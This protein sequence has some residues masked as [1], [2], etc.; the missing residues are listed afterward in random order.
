MKLKNAI[1]VW[2]RVVACLALVFSLVFFQPTVSH[3]AS[4]MHGSHQVVSASSDNGDTRHEHDAASSLSTQEKSGSV[5]KSHD[6][7][8]ISGECC[9]DF[10]ISVV[11]GEDGYVL[12]AQVT[13]DR[14][15]ALRAQTASIEPSGF[16]RP[17][18]YL[19]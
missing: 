1:S 8:Q 7:D 2:I 12:F 14:Y 6:K 9:S 11:L 16:L 10:C 3:A 15:L 4:G 5:S 18:Q 17:P 19:I 13:G